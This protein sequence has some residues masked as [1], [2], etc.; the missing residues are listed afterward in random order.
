[1]YQTLFDLAGI[2]MVGWL[3]LILL[4]TWRV[5]RRVAESAIFPVF[6]SVLYLIGIAAVLRESGPGFMG[7]FGSADGVLGLLQQESIALIAWIHILAFDHAIGILIYRDNMKHR[8]VPVPVQ[9]V[10]LAA[11]LM[12]GP[13]G[14]L[15]YWAVR[16][17]R[18]GNPRTAW[19]V[20]DDPGGRDVSG[21]G[22]VAG[23]T[24]EAPRYED[25]VTGSSLAE[26]LGGLW[27]R[28]RLVTGVGLLGFMFAAATAA[29]AIW[30]GGWLLAPE[31]RLLEAIK[32]DVALGIYTLTV[33]LILPLA[34]MTAAGRR[35]WVGW[36]VG[37]TLFAYLMENVQ[38]W[39][40]LDPRF[41]EVAGPIDQMLGGLFFLQAL[42]LLVLFVILMRGFFRADALPDRQA[43][44]VSLRY[45]TVGALMAFGVGI[46]MSALSG[47]EFGAAGDLM[48][49]HAAGFHA[50]QAVPLIAL[51]A[52]LTALDARD[53]IRWTHIG[54][55]GWLL[56]CA[57]LVLQAVV[58]QPPAAS[59]PM[60]GLSI[61][62]ALT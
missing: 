33:A 51:L 23:A 25:V 18:R 41:S 3:L 60:L 59:T 5:T 49:I 24:P 4:P 21:E 10:L 11:T 58:G 9:S 6:L 34:T 13:V 36:T 44:R 27:R 2:A 53:A 35:R 8:Y 57:G 39:R 30:N 1:M 50:L 19:G 43:L 26:R 29:V 15:G 40:G 22:A 20:R 47:R 28:H 17:V 55:A 32:F 46:L 7:E 42:G 48:L 61:L 45:S 56:L 16:A 62:G 12:L 54:G 14:F 52:G 37:L 38:A 31:G